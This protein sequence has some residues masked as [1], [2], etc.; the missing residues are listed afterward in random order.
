MAT[1]FPFLF[2]S[3]SLATGILLASLLPL[4]PGLS[5]GGIAIGLAAAWTAYLARKNRAA[6]AAIL[7]AA[8]FIGSGL[9]SKENSDYEKNPVKLFSFGDYADFTGRLFRS[10]GFAVGKTYLYLSV[11]RISF[12]NQDVEARGNLRV[13]VLHPDKYPSPVRLR[14]GDRVKVSA[15]V[16]PQRDFRNFGE[17]GL[18]DLRKN[19]RIHNHAVTKSALLVERLPGSDGP[20]A[21]RWVSSVRLTWQKKIEEFFSA[22]DGSALTQEGAVL[23][24]LLLGE[25]G[26]L[27]GATTAVLQRSGLYHVIA[28]SG[29]HIAVI[30]FLLFSALHLLR[31]PRRVSYA[32]LILVLSLYAILVEGRASVFRAVI[33]TLVYL[34]GKLLWKKSHVLNTISLSACLLLAGN[35]F[36]LFDMGF[37]LTFAATLSI[38]LFYPGVIRR[39]PRLPL[40]ISELFALSLTAQ[41]GV[42]PFLARSF[43]R[44]TFA[45]LFLNFLAIPL[46]GLIMALGFVFL[47]AALVS[48]FISRLLA[49]ALAGLTRVFL[50][51]TGLADPLPVLSYRIPTPHLL[52]VIGYFACLLIILLRPRFK[53]QR[54][55]SL[56]VFAAFAAVLVTYP[57]PPRLSRGLELT[58]LDVGQGDSILVEFPGR[59][60]MLLD[61]GGVAD[62]SLDIGELVVSPYLWDLGIKKLDYV[63]LTHAHPDH[64]N[65]LKSVVRNFRVV[66]FWEGVS[67][68]GNPAHQDLM[69][70]LRPSVARE[71]VRR[72]FSRREGSVRVEAL[73]PEPEAASGKE[74]ANDQ[75]LVLRLSLGAQ[76]FLLPGDIGSAAE[77]AVVEGGA[78]IRAQVLKSPH[79]GS[80]TSSSPGF[81]DAVRP[82]IVIVTA[83][84]GNFYGLP[85]PDII[86]RYSERGAR[87][88][89]TDEDGAVRVTT[90]GSTLQV[91]TSV[92]GRRVPRAEP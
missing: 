38:I 6:F 49:Q 80:R 89:R 55:V 62:D 82:E 53:G 15:R 90:E 8:L 22:A 85:H 83:G 32:A 37:Q 16:L 72:G 40:K 43:H 79:H 77:A 5:A 2:L 26:R 56:G 67:P 12:L 65:G 87:V 21:L 42:M 91:W 1:P 41:L 57:F 27:A 48:P 54:L 30:A 19:Q 81:L 74:I 59:K 69:N 10:P 92:G 9:Y 25:R 31:V 13:T 36:Y 29:A 61:A 86:T 71:A 78:D 70:G 60:K 84:R 28:I 68:A 17:S 23:E 88:F 63:V 50:W 64:L 44:V 45:G 73:H 14:A 3:V 51:T 18:A 20:S 52:T 46:T 58:F 47:G 75:S 35:P 76:S 33:M 66:E 34:A 24:A 39:L 7:L 11:E 4:A